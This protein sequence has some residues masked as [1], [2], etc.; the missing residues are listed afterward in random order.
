MLAL[1]GEN[2]DKE[3]R[4]GAVLVDFW[5][6]WCGPCRMLAPVF[7]SLSGEIK[8]V[9]FAKVNVDQEPQLAE[10]FEVSSIPTL[11]LLKDGREVARRVGAA[12]KEALREWVSANVK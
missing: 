2:F 10:R 3:T 5:A 7:E 11:V 6:E 8:G 12:T 4:S 1:S 9:K